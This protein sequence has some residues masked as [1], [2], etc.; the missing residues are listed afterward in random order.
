MR[1]NEAKFS[2]VTVYKWMKY[3]YCGP[4]KNKSKSRNSKR[5]RWLGSP[6]KWYVH[7]M[8]FGYAPGYVGEMNTSDLFLCGVTVNEHGVPVIGVPTSNKA[9]KTNR[10]RERKWEKRRNKNNIREW[11]IN[12]GENCVSTKGRGLCA[13]PAH[14]APRSTSPTIESIMREKW[15]LTVSRTV[16]KERI[17]QC[18]SWDAISENM[19]SVHHSHPE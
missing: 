7:D 3:T 19:Q 8:S 2:T 9:A 1:K 15:S 13:L 11:N 6:I 18:S 4:P 16:N 10:E 17:I 5:T 12:A 14:S